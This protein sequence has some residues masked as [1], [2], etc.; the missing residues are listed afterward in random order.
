MERRRSAR[1]PFKS[2]AFVLRNGEF[3]SSE[4]KDVNN[5]GIFLNTRCHFDEGERTLVSIYLQEGEISL[6]VTLPCAVARVSDSGIG[7]TSPHLE[8][9]AFLFMSN[10]IHSHKATPVEFMQFFYKSMDWFELHSDS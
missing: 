4:T 7:C 8:P 5:G 6:S 1:T 10:L 3:V 2:H 9:E